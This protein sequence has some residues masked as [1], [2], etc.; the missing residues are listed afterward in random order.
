MIE[1]IENRVCAPEAILQVGLLHSVTLHK[2]SLS[3]VRHEFGIRVTCEVI[4]VDELPGGMCS[5]VS[6]LMSL[7][8]HILAVYRARAEPCL[9]C[10]EFGTVGDEVC[11]CDPGT[12]GPSCVKPEWTTWSTWSACSASCGDGTVQRIRHCNVPEGYACVDGASVEEQPCDAGACASEWSDWSACPVSCSTSMS[13]Q[14]I[15]GAQSRGRTCLGDASCEG[16]AAKQSR[17]C[18]EVCPIACPTADPFDNCSGHGICE[19][20]PER[21]CTQAATCRY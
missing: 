11:V 6:T 16:V 3:R 14:V 20:T 15:R 17:E 5:R 18:S 8:Q 2:S 7:L 4:E 9:N 10:G 21:G 13:G 1:L 19:L 12:V